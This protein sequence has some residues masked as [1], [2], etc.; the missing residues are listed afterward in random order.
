MSAKILLEIFSHFA[1]LLVVKTVWQVCEWRIVAHSGAFAGRFCSQK[2]INR[3]FSFRVGNF[4]A[5]R[6]GGRIISQAK[7]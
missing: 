1:V 6:H 7:W 3:R 5:L 4:F 2:A